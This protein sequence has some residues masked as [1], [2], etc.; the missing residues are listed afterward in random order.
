MFLNPE[1]L[2]PASVLI[3]VQ[4]SLLT[5]IFYTLKGKINVEVNDGPFLWKREY[6]HKVGRVVFPLLLVGSLICDVSALQAY[7][8]HSNEQLADKE[9][10]ESLKPVLAKAVSLKRDAVCTYNG[11][12]AGAE[13]LE[14]DKIACTQI[15]K[16]RVLNPGIDRSTVY[17]FRIV[18]ETE[19]V[20]VIRNGYDTIRLI[21]GETT[22]EELNTVFSIK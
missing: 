9:M 10:T 7:V 19:V 12:I 17:M 2:I 18:S 22:V 11:Y 5:V 20:Q 3:F 15:G 6:E 16:F 13:T 1:F 14:R 8:A 4:V 21:D